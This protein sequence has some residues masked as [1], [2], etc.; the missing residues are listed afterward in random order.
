MQKQ[1]KTART[2]KTSSKVRTVWEAITGTQ[3]LR[4][5][6]I[7]ANGKMVETGRVRHAF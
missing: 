6:I 7:Y 1:N 2:H 4:E 5:L 3:T